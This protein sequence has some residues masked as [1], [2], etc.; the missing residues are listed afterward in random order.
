MKVLVWTQYFWPETFLINK[1]VSELYEQGIEVTVVTGKPNYP[2]GSLFSG[3]TAWGVQYESYSDVEIIRLPLAPRGKNSA[4]KLFL[5]YL[6]F[7]FSG[8]II[9][10][11]ILRGKHFDAVFVYAPSPLLQ[12]LPAIFISWLKGVPLIVWVQDIWPDALQA[13]GF[14]KNTWLLKMV[15][16]AVRYIYRYSDLLLI[17]SEAFRESVQ[18]LISD[19]RKIHFFP[20]FAE[21]LLEKSSLE[22]ISPGKKILANINAIQTD[23]SIVFAGNIGSAQSCETIVQ[24]AE[25]LQQYSHIRFYLVG[26]GSRS[27]T[28]MQ[29]INARGLSNVV[30]TGRLPPENMPAIFSAADVLLLTLKDDP[31][32]YATIPSKMQSYMSAAKPIIACLNGEAARL[33][34]AAD[35]GVSCLAEAHEELA[36]AVLQLYELPVDERARLGGNA[37]QYYEKHFHLTEKLNELIDHFRILT[38]K[39]KFNGFIDR[40]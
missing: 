2:E 1:L 23:F 27:E 40:K 25:L 18:S 17:Q 3:Y 34:I 31:A 24:A 39:Y 16:W 19:K 36:A 7:I 37:R 29:T 11:W 12:T 28:I 4:R 26:S 32:L 5:N 6:S 21:D 8:Y 38:R 13:T 14:I 15:E 20:N 35:A 33:V 10:P 22:N 30:M 9:A